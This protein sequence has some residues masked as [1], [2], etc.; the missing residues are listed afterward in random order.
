MSPT[1]FSTARLLVGEFDVAEAA[2]KDAFLEVHAIGY[3]QVSPVTV[4]HPTEMVD[5]G[6]S[7]VERRVLME[8][9]EGAGSRRVKIWVGEALSD[10]RVLGVAYGM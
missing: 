1:P 4:I 7:A 3:F 2:L 8:L 5:G 6:L 10:E 9:G